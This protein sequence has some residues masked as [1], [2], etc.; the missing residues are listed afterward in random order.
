[1]VLRYRQE[2]LS[3]NILFVSNVNLNDLIDQVDV[4]VT[5]MSQTAYVALIRERAVVTL[6]YNQ[7]RHKGCNYEAY[8]KEDIERVLKDAISHGYTSEQRQN[9]ICHTAQLL[10]YYLYD[11]LADRP[12][13]YGKSIKN[14]ENKNWF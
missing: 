13:R 3:P 14:L 8:V 5:L 6:G 1:M 2:D 12:I 4:V 10:K 11:N 7:L 9:F